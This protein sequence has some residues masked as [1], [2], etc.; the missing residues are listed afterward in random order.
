MHIPSRIIVF[1][2]LFVAFCVLAAPVAANA[3]NAER[4]VTNTVPMDSD[5]TVT[6]ENHDGEINITT[7]NRSEVQ[8]EARIVHEDEDTV[9]DTR[10]RTES[11]DSEVE[12]ESDFD[13]VEKSGFWGARSVPD[14]FYTLR[15]PAG[16][17][18]EIDDHGSA[19]NV[20]GLQGQVDVDSH[21]GGIQLSR[22]GGPVRID[23]HDGAI[24]LRDITGAVEIDS[25]DGDVTASGLR[26][27]LTV[28][29][30]DGRVNA[31]FSSLD[32]PVEIDSHDARVRLT[33]P[34][35]AAFTLQT[36]MGD[37]GNVEVEPEM[38]LTSMDE[39]DIEA[40][41]NGGGPEIYVSAHDGS[42]Q[43]ETQ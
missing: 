9:R 1:V 13:D 30:H 6:V 19:I 29:T 31:A 16:A 36:D 35:G 39:G 5:G 14:V 24:D 15:V 25:H 43:I 12:I 21:D 17:S 27:P 38:S 23:T 4:T 33:L 28:D 11:S 41:V 3:Q 22:I 37:D 32:G 10:I 20:D 7:W 34:T 42:L 2:S 18:L 8:V 26:G 40:T